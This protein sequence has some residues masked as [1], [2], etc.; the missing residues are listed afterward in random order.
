MAFFEKAVPVWIAGQEREK[1]FTCGFMARIDF[2]PGKRVV[3]RAA[4][5]AY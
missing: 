3:L 4:A 5:S 2:A 1:N